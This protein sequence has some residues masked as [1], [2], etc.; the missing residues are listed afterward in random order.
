MVNVEVNLKFLVFYRNRRMLANTVGLEIIEI[1]SRR[2]TA[3]RQKNVI[4]LQSTS[5]S[6]RLF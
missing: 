4:I 1:D 3:G 6:S 5:T 2:R